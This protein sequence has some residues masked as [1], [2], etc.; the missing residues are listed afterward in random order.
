MLVSEVKSGTSTPKKSQVQASPRGGLRGGGYRGGFSFATAPTTPQRPED[1]EELAAAAAEEQ[2][3]PAPA[4]LRADD[5]A[6]P[7]AGAAALLAGDA[8]RD[9][10][11]QQGLQCCRWEGRGYC[12]C[13]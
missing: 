13:E 1:E 3:L 5:S 12:A 9:V 11:N 10:T 8:P 2:P 7:S 4:A 6:A